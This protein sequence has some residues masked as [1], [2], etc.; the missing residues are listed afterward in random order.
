MP[1]DFTG[2]LAGNLH[3]PTDAIEM[4]Q[5]NACLVIVL[6][7]DETVASHSQL[8]KLRK[9]RKIAGAVPKRKVKGSARSLGIAAQ[10]IARW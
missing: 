4:Y 3:Y 1:S 9:T 7:V 8:G 5:V 2:A 6:A 10:N